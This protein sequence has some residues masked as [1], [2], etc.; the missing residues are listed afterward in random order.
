MILNFSI[1]KYIFILFFIFITILICINTSLIQTKIIN[2][3]L[4][5]I[6]KEFN[7][8][9]KVSLH[10]ININFF[11]DTINI[12]NIQVLDKYNNIIFY[13][14]IVK[15]KF[16]IFNFFFKK[17]YIKNIIINNPLIYIQTYKGD[18]NNNLYNLIND[19]NK[20]NNKLFILKKIIY[21]NFIIN[22][23]H[24]KII[25]YNYKNN[26]IF[27]SK[28]I[29]IITNNLLITN[30]LIKF[31][32]SKINISGL[33]N[34]KFLSYQFFLQNV[35]FNSNKI[36]IF[37]TKINTKNS[38]ISFS[39][40][41]FY[42]KYLDIIY[43][44]KN[45]F[46]IFNIKKGSYLSFNDINDVKLFNP[47]K[48]KNSKI[49]FY[50]KIGGK[51]NHNIIIENFILK[52]EKNLLK[53]DKIILF[54]ILNKK[55]FKIFNY[56]NIYLQIFYQKF[57][58]YLPKYIIN[59]IPIYFK[60]YGII[61][62][63][64]AIFINNNNIKIQGKF[65]INKLLFFQ[66]Q[67]NIFDYINS[68]IY[69]CKGNIKII[70]ALIIKYFNIN[71]L[72]SNIS[73][74][75]SHLLS[76][77]MK[78]HF[79][80]MINKIILNNNN[81]F[82]NINIIV[83]NIINNYYIVIYINKILSKFK[84]YIKYNFFSKKYFITSLIKINKLYLK[85][86]N[87]YINTIFNTNIYSKIYIYNIYNI[88]IKIFIDNI[89]L[90]LN[91]KKIFFDKVFIN[92][93]L[94][95]KYYK[96]LKIY[97]PNYINTYYNGNFNF[98]EIKNIFYQYYYNKNIYNSSN[99]FFNF[100][101]NIN[102]NL[103]HLFNK[104]L[105]LN[106]Y[107]YYLYGS[108][109]NDIIFHTKIKKKQK[110]ILKNLSL[111]LDNKNYINQF[112]I[113][114]NLL[115]KTIKLK[116]INFYTKQY[117]D[118][119]S[120]IFNNNILL[121]NLRQE[122]ELNFYKK[123]VK[124]NNILGIDNSF[125]KINH[126]NW[127][128][129][130]NNFN[131]NKFYIIHF[132]N[133]KLILPQINLIN[134]Y[135]Q[136]NIS[137]YIKYNKYFFIEGIFNDLTLSSFLDKK[138]GIH[139][140]IKGNFFIKVKNTNLIIEL[141]CK[142]HKLYI[143]NINIGNINCNFLYKNKNNNILFNF[144]IN[145]YYINI[146]NISIYNIY[147]LHNSY[148]I[149]INLN[150]ISIRVIKD[151][152]DYI[153]NNFR[154]NISGKININI[155]NNKIKYQGYLYL[156]NIGMKLNYLNIDYEILGIP[157]M[158]INNN[159]FIIN[160]FTIRDTKYN[161]LGYI[162]G[163]I[164]NYNNKWI[165]SISI[166]AK[167]IL[168]MNT[169]LKDTS[170]YGTIFI[171]GKLNILGDKNNINIFLQEGKISNFSKL[172]INI[173]NNDYNQ[174]EILNPTF[175]KFIKENNIKKNII[176]KTKN[177]NQFEI[178]NINIQ[179]DINEKCKIY[180]IPY[181]INENYF[182]KMIGN[183]N[184]LFKINS[185]DSIEMIGKY[186]IKN[187][188]F[189]IYDNK[190]PILLEINKKIKLKNGSMINWIGNPSNPELNIF[191]IIPNH[192]ILKL[193]NYIQKSKY[194]NIITNIINHTN[195]YLVESNIKINILNINTYIK[196][197]LYKK[198]YS[199]NEPIKQL[200]Y[201]LFKNKLFINK[202]DNLFEILL[203]N[204]YDNLLNK[205]EYYLSE[206]NNNIFLNIEYLK[207]KNK[208]SNNIKYNLL[209]NINNFFYLKSILNIP[210]NNNFN[211]KYFMN[212]KIYFNINYKYNNIKLFFLYK[213]NNNNYKHFIYGFK[214]FSKFSFEKF[215]DFIT[216]YK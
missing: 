85:N 132:Y 127:I 111:I 197:F 117:K 62:Y 144:I 84:I 141:N 143:N 109:N 125:I 65:I 170:L 57:L 44:Q 48:L 167:D 201:F 3:T 163:Y 204:Y 175:L 123:K 162:N 168:S 20:K 45:I 98:Y 193:E 63:I 21:I 58:Q 131:C 215:I 34:N 186:Y 27:L 1:K 26:L 166:D 153:S 135:K 102:N 110:Y 203:F 18:I 152:D 159:N 157:I 195:N 205:L 214:F 71:Y 187:G 23:A 176:K 77:K 66:G 192:L 22:N 2:Y 185:Y 38:N 88:Y 13:L 99:N 46:F 181:T 43:N 83:N 139:G 91:L 69:N 165:T 35:Y 81:I 179:S 108:F 169:I 118:G 148:K 50:G 82:Y 207:Y 150:N 156:K 151:I 53:L 200:K 89:N 160:N 104:N 107:N 183:G 12:K 190:I 51:I 210:I 158:I 212:G 7:N 61:K 15:I 72:I 32:K 122:A 113:I 184:I 24:L 211:N 136:I 64:G 40:S 76:N 114:D 213:K 116:N 11:F 129:N 10:R 206:I 171:N 9:I 14:P 68:K 202:K 191:T 173:Y 189:N 128:I 194:N 182:I 49:F 59:K 29:N 97:I 115:F 86:K 133:K 100:K 93:N 149:N 198:I 154:G 172:Y 174:Y 140:I 134:N 16:N 25:N 196:N 142:I 8:K 39:F 177:K 5:R 106:I 178:F 92:F 52:N 79:H 103:I 105:L 42:K 17:I 112:F 199:K 216:N 19:L 4:N 130:N 145:N 147:Y 30:N 126:N 73:F 56:Y 155:Y 80:G 37:F 28:K 137:T 101:L 188:Y 120:L 67:F 75:G 146:I 55:K 74:N 121:Y 70:D 60:K 36:T 164:I 96:S 31:K 180:L 119:I 94:I 138:Y 90:I 124:N 95:N 78:I 161:T 33:L 41:L 87:L 209:Y 54:N 208:L 6:N 47:F